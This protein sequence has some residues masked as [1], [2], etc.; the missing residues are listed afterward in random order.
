MAIQGFSDNDVNAILGFRPRF[1]QHTNFAAALPVLQAVQQLTIDFAGALEQHGFIEVFDWNTWLASLGRPIEDPSLLA[2][3]DVDTLRKVITTHIRM[4]RF[5]R[6]HLESLIRTG[7]FS[8]FLDRLQ[9]L[10]TQG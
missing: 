5:V 4:E 9:V 8:A 2:T 6:G 1:E 10:N 7:Y 3:A